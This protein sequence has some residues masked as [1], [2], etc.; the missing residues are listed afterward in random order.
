MYESIPRV[1]IP[2]P[3]ETMGH[4]LCMAF[5]G[6]GNFLAKHC[7]RAGHCGT[8]GPQDLNQAQSQRTM[9]VNVYLV[10][11]CKIRLLINVQ[12]DCLNS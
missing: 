6:V 1:T 8:Q 4:L 3:Q 11:F 9:G 7:T 2:P 12:I 5:P 10:S